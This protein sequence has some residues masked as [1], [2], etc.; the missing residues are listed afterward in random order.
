MSTQLQVHKVLEIFDFDFCG[1][2]SQLQGAGLRLLG[3]G[4]VFLLKRADSGMIQ[5][6]IS[7]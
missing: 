6:E 4:K 5:R 2:C 1:V 7:R 3:G